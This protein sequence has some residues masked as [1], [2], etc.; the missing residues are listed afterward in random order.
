MNFYH[1]STIA[2]ALAAGIV[3]SQRCAAEADE[4]PK[5]Q[6]LLQA[7]TGVT[8]SP[9]P[10]GECRMLPR[11]PLLGNGEVGVA[12]SGDEKQLSFFF[13]RADSRRRAIGGVDVFAESATAAPLK[14][15]LEQDLERAEVRGKLTF[16]DAPL[17]FTSWLVP[18][19]PLMICELRN[20]S[21]QPLKI[22]V[23][24]WTRPPLGLQQPFRLLDAGIRDVCNGLWDNQGKVEYSKST[25]D[26]ADLW[27]W[28]KVGNAPRLK[29]E[30]TGRYLA[31]MPSGAVEAHEQP[32]A[33]TEMTIETKA[34][35]GWPG[36]LI[37]SS[38]GVFLNLRK[39]DPNPRNYWW[40]PGTKFSVIAEK[41][42]TPYGTGIEGAAHRFF[43]E[44][45]GNGGGIC[46]AWRGQSQIATRVLDAEAA[47]ADATATFT[48]PPNGSVTVA[49]A[50]TGAAP[51][52]TAEQSR[53]VGVALVKSLTPETVQALSAARLAEWKAYWLKAWLDTGD[54]QFNRFWFASM[55]LLKCTNRAGCQSP[56]LYGVWNTSDHPV[57]GNNEFN[58]YNYQAQ[59]YGTFTANRAEL[60]TPQF[61]DILKALPIAQRQAGQ[62]GYRGAMWGRTV[63]GHPSG[64]SPTKFPQ[65]PVA[66]R[67]NR[68]ALD[69]DQLDAPAFLAMNFL[70]AYE[71][72][73]DREFLAKKAW[74]MI[75]A[76]ADFYTDYLTFNKAKNRY[77]IH[78]S[79]SREA[80]GNEINAACQLA[81]IKRVVAAAADYSEILGVD[82]DK[83][84][85]WRDIVAKM[86]AYPTM[87]VDGK[88]VFK[89]SE[90]RNRVALHG[91]GDNCSLLQI[92]HP[93]ADIG[94][95]SDPKLVETARNTIAWLNSDPAKPSWLNI[96]N[97]L[98]LIFVD[99]ASVGWDAADLHKWFRRYLTQEERPN[100]TY[101]PW[102]VESVGATEGL[103]RMLLQSHEDVLRFFPVW[104]K[105]KNASFTRL[106]AKGAFLVSAELKNGEVCGVRILS[107]K[108]RDLTVQN[109]WPGKKVCVVRT[110]G[111]AGGP[112]AVRAPGEDSAQSSAKAST[113]NGERFT[114]KTSVGETIELRPE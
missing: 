105:D 38:H 84:G 114:L 19:Q 29:N 67:K 27:R 12:V 25:V 111:S 35:Y 72:T 77:E 49:M 93:G 51:G 97:N 18:D 20:P 64:P 96:D 4:W 26:G 88:T 108:G 2:I 22:K 23:R 98:P 83:R 92:I 71:T 59:H 58:N 30:A 80:S 14:A 3:G 7:A 61:D 62:A 100:L 52:K 40:D 17:E 8:E 70:Y 107:E 42:R 63:A 43:P 28:A 46:W 57:C 91:P 109:P 36:L 82:A 95:D 69:N 104:P 31:L 75:R 113:T 15:R 94:L 10:P 53:A 99:A 102:G 5:L 90:N 16:G 101:Q 110:P 55:Y 74:P 78:F 56:A 89:E 45:A 13:G 87:E 6:P 65:P 68:A 76:C 73:L 85:K 60:A 41:K 24:T 81:M 21:G 106:R 54:P 33:S 9:L 66:G 32:D 50:V 86:S 44:T 11:A 103:H 1:T 48:L 34:Q 79:A 47:I 37:I 112:P 39:D